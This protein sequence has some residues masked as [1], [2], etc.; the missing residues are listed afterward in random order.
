MNR[1]SGGSGRGRRPD[2]SGRSSGRHR[3]PE[4]EPE[5]DDVE[6]DGLEVDGQA[7]LAQG[8]DP[9]E[10]LREQFKKTPWWLIAAAFHGLLLA[11][12]TVIPLERPEPKEEPVVQV[13]I[14]SKPRPKLQEIERPRGIF[15]RAGIPKPGEQSPTQEPAIFFP[16]AEESDHN[17]SADGE[18]YQQMKG[19]SFDNLSYLPGQDKGT[20]GRGTT[21]AGHVD[22]MGVGGGSGAAGRYGGRFGGRKN[23]V[24]RG[25]GTH[26]T[27]SAVLAGLRWLARH[28]SEDGSWK[29]EAF[30]NQCGG[31]FKCSGHGY[32]QFDA[33]LTGLSLLAF[34]GAGFTH[35]SRS[36]YEDPYTHKKISF[37][38]CV[39]KGL[40]YLI[41]VQDQ[42]GCFGTRTGEFMYNHSIAALAMT[43][44]YGLTNAAVYRF[45]AQK[46]IDF[47]TVAQNPYLAWR[48]HVK[49]GENDTSVTGWCI[50]AL[51]SAEISELTTS[52]TCFDGARAWID[53]VTNKET[54]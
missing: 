41:S 47:I 54:G 11:I 16:G 37:G 3:E 12:T 27:E 25:G 42:E 23:R 30:D 19:D 13:G 36:S 48:Y 9:A 8:F 14:Q 5:Q 20:K 2:E 52:R 40:D 15:D 6:L 29:A 26:A 1:T 7:T 24:A 35:L 45:P 34:L 31:G 10:F 44:A 4:P 33:G 17:E 51:K 22:V 46:G 38:Q 43:E 53:R 18:D 28:Q 39:R 21:G 49:P 50:M 32:A